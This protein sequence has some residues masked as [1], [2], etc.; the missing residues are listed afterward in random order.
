MKVLIATST[1]IYAILWLSCN[2]KGDQKWE[3]VTIDPTIARDSTYQRLDKFREHVYG[4]EYPD[5]SAR[6]TS[7]VTYFNDNPAVINWETYSKSNYCRAFFSKSDTLLIRI[8]N[9]SQFSGEGFTIHYIS[10]MFFVEPFSWIDY[11]IEGAPEP[12]YELVYQHVTLNKPTYSTGDSLYGSVDF[13]SIET[14]PDGVK[15]QHT[16]KGLFR[17]KIIAY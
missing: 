5:S 6:R 14:T 13:K 7:D 11:G 2:K 3:E 16:G 8:G 12:S 17:T 15:R 1:L 10:K 4:T 9:E